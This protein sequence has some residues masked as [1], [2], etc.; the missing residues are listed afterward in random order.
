MTSFDARTA[1]ER[2][3][4]LLPGQLGFEIIAVSPDLVVGS[5]LVALRHCTTGGILHGGA[6]M[7]LGDT[8]GA[9][10]T[11]ANLS[12]GN[13]TVTVES[14]TK[15]IAPAAQGTVV[16]GESRPLHRGRTTMVWQTKLTRHDGRL[17]AIVSQTQLILPAERQ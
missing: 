4:P 1:Q 11:V 17:C 9:L 15:F 5:L 3:A 13:R 6:I 2:I 7:A 14:S 12:P 10:G 8:L 16:T